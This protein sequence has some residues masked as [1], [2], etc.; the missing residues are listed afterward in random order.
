VILP[1]KPIFLTVKD[2]EDLKYCLEWYA[3][4]VICFDQSD[5]KLKKELEKQGIKRCA[6]VPVKSDA[7]ALALINDGFSYNLTNNTNIHILKN[8]LIYPCSVLSTA[9]KY[10]D[11]GAKN[12][13]WLGDRAGAEYI[14]SESVTIYYY[15]DE[16]VKGYSNLD[17]FD[18]VDGFWFNLNDKFLDFIKGQL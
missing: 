14:K 12:I 8:T 16:T 9:I 1:D 15:V 7:A 13:L 10:I 4:N 5:K 17:K 3:P 11:H 6:S 2:S 18:F